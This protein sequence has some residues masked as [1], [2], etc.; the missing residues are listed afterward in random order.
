MLNK[1][2]GKLMKGTRYL[3]YLLMIIGL[4]LAGCQALPA[5]NSIPQTGIDAAPAAAPAVEIRSVEVL[6]SADP[7]QTLLIVQAVLPDACSRLGEAVV[8]RQGQVFTVSLPGERSA[9]QVG[10]PPASLSQDRVIRLSA[11]L[12][13]PGN[14]V[15]LVNGVLS[16]F[17]IAN[18]VQ[19]PRPRHSQRPADGSISRGPTRIG[20]WINRG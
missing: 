2:D 13:A 15:A 4:G 11:D 16:S 17:R 3:F 10:C 12:L 5:A 19:R 1:G 9:G 6:H 8:E 20:G 14:Y 7:Q 18:N